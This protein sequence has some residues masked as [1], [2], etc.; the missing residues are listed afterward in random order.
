MEE[1]S[2]ILNAVLREATF[3]MGTS[4]VSAFS[5][6]SSYG[7][8]PKEALPASGLRDALDRANWHGEFVRRAREARLVCPDSLLTE[9]DDFVRPLLEK[10][11]DPETDRVGHAFPLVGSGGSEGI[12][13]QGNGMLAVAWTSPVETFVEGLV[14]GAAVVGAERTAALLADWTNGQP[15]K[16]QTFALLNGGYLSRPLP[17]VP[18]VAI[19]ELP[20]SV[21]D[22][23]VCLRASDA[24][25]PQQ[26]LGQPAVSID[27]SVAP[28][29]F[30]PGR[31]HLRRN[32]QAEAATDLDVTAVCQTLSLVANGHFDA[33]FCCHDYGEISLFS[34]N[35]ADTYWPVGPAGLRNRP[36]ASISVHRNPNTA[37]IAL[38]LEEQPLH[39]LENDEL[40]GM[41]NTIAACRRAESHS[42]VFAAISRWMRSKD[43]YENLSDQFIDLR[44]AFELLY[45]QGSRSELRSRVALSGA[46]HL[47]R[48]PEEREAIHKT[49]RYA[50]DTASKAV[51][52]GALEENADNVQLLAEAQDICRRSIIKLLTEGQSRPEQAASGT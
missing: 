30:Q 51:H 44:I 18:G 36:Y 46:W 52:G 7:E 33:G 25:T 16:Y 39:D 22:P 50:Y 45:C 3:D 32:I 9:L 5:R 28:P 8:R 38:M 6:S 24:I 14:V 43:R 23:P 37:S 10:Y 47:G 31:E 26:L 15:V 29:L 2:N 49:L 20:R 40:V 17:P 48:N 21:E 12:W 35:S 27:T 41:L 13:A 1:L 4:E 42:Q 11:V 19:G 34:L